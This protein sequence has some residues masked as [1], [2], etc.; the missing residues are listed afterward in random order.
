VRSVDDPLLMNFDPVHISAHH[1]TCTRTR[2]AL[3]H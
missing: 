1:H 3:S 2:I